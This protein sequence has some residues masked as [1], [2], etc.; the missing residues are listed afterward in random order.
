[1]E[2]DDIPDDEFTPMLDFAPG[3]R[4]MP[5]YAENET[6]INQL[7]QMN[8]SLRA[9]MLCVQITEASDLET[10]LQFITSDDYGFYNHPF[11]EQENSSTC[12]ICSD[13]KQRHVDSLDPKQ[14]E[15]GR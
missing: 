13:I 8:F 6:I 10:V 15:Q 12:I 14:F 9:A 4:K 11:I 3:L 2:A 1:M 5:S 7:V